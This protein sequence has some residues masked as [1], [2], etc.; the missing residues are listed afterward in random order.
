M[1]VTP[2]MQQYMAV[3]ERVPDCL[4]FFRLGDFYEMFY[5]DAEIGSRELE[6]TLT[7]RAA[8]KE[9]K[10]PMCGVPYHAAE[11]Y[12]YRLIQKG[13]RVA[14]CEQLEDPKATKGL[15][16]RDI[17][18]IVTP[19]TIL[20]ENAIAA[21]SNNYLAYIVEGNGTIALLLADISTGECAWG[22]WDTKK[23]TDGF[24]DMLSVHNPAEAVLDVSDDM[25]LKIES[26]AAARLG[27]CLLERRSEEEETAALP[28]IA[29]EIQD[30]TVRQAMRGLAGYLAE[31]MRG[32]VAGIRTIRSLRE[33]CVM[34]LSEETLRNLEITRNMWDSGRRGTLLEILDYTETPMG[35][36]LLRR[37]LERPLTDINAITLRQDAIEELCAHTTELAK[38]QGL[39]SKIFDFERILTR[40]EAN[41]T[42]PKDLLSLKA[43][44]SVL[45][46]LKQLL[47][48]ASSLLLRKLT[49]NIHLHEAVYTLLDSAMDENG[50]GN[51]KDGHYI[52]A[53]YNAE[54]DELRDV[55]ENS[56]RFIA[57]LEER[58]KD[59]TGIKLK[60]GFNNVFGYYF[61]ISHANKLPI[62]DYYVRKQ[63]LANAERYITPEL[64]E[65]EIKALTAKEKTEQLEMKLYQDVKAELRPAVS[66]ILST[67]R[68][69]GE[70]DTLAS[71]SRAAVKERLTRPQIT[72]EEG[73]S[74]TEGRHPMMARALKNEMFVPND[75]RLSH[76]DAEIHI[77]TGPNM[78]G[79]STYMRQVAIL[80]LLAQTGSFIPA[81]SAAI[82]PVDRIFTRIGATDDI[83]NG[84][85]TFMVEMQEV[86]AILRAATKRSLIIM[87]EIGRGT[88]TYDGMSIA[89]AVVEYLEKKI[90]AYTLFATHYHELAAMEGMSSVIKNFTVTVKER[91]KDIT[92]LRRIV[93]GSADKSY[94]IHVARLAGLPESLLSRAEEILEGLET[95]GAAPRETKPQA[96][97]TPG[98]GDLFADPIIEKLKQID[99]LALT[100]I[101]AI[102]TLYQLSQEAKEA[103]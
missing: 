66:D 58:E 103:H 92:F 51:V 26:Y 16:K 95:E 25:Y 64:K 77:I 60:I 79:K 30:E 87:D 83:L 15:V 14:I 85:S 54:L 4:V 71:L 69:I 32:D 34:L 53:G 27:G 74:I 76:K 47:G 48:G 82:C 67:A 89:R 20:Y 7:A 80:V 18:K 31:V 90:H 38:L 55:T 21:K 86:S 63:T 28:D 62:P 78:A 99:A 72:R 97:P 11:T 56:R 46:E 70:V 57:E 1:S 49:E 9:E 96:A 6:L 91:G 98:Y 44:L 81:K 73:I 45:P 50:T 23:E 12:I 65:F 13:Y 17:V 88:S 52:K 93:P 75:T 40:I 41:T 84:Q 37:W 61:E 35:A 19:G 94:G 102:N 100:P 59:K 101:E 39:L 5:E 33:D 2:F 68:A 22:T 10:A 24:L 29:A 42:S 3:K 8:G 36:R 43:S